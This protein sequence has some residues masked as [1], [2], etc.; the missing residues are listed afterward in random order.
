MEAQSSMP[1]TQK[2]LIKLVPLGS[3]Q[4]SSTKSETNRRCKKKPKIKKP[5]LK[6][7]LST[8]ERQ[9]ADV[10]NFLG[11]HWLSDLPSGNFFLILR[12]VT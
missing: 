12:F 8:P 10:A 5:P 4:V 11:G 7:K 3:L 6:K 9:V 2:S 1:I